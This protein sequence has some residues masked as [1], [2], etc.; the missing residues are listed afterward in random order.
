MKYNILNVVY[1]Q[2][3]SQL[4]LENH[5]KSLLDESNLP[6]LAKKHDIHYYIFSDKPTFQLMGPHPNINKLTNLVHVEG[7]PFVKEPTYATRYDCLG[8]ALREGI[9]SSLRRDA[10]LTTFAADHVVAKG[11]FDRLLDPINN[12]YG[13]VF[14]VPMRAAAEAV[15]RTISEATGA[16]SANELFNLGYNNLHPLWNASHYEA[17][18]F[19]KIPYTMLW[20]SGSGLMARSFSISPMAFKVNEKMLKVNMA[21]Y[22]LPGMCENPYWAVNWDEVP[23]MGAEPLLCFYP[24]FANMK[25]LP[26][27]IGGHWGKHLNVKQM[28]YVETP[29]YFP[30]MEVAKIPDLQK[31]SSDEA[32]KWIQ[33]EYFAATGNDPNL[34]APQA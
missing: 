25:A 32:I 19:S 29:F 28:K 5:L 30:N 6:A 16:L 11:F 31:H 17:A 8:Q 20:N 34:P 1:G 3:Y 12:G 22:D 10:V 27:Y 26:E 21:D 23:M 7:I 13:A 24:P 14:S 15:Q 18:Q 2:Q 33:R 9:D 4:F